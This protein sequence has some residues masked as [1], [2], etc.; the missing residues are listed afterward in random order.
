MRYY[1]LLLCLALS[2]CDLNQHP[3]DSMFDDYVGR[4]ANV[5]AEQALPLP[6]TQTTQLPDKSELTLAIEPIT[7]GLLDSYELRKCG[8]F[9]IIA[10][11]NSVL[12]KVQ[13]Q[14]REFDFQLALFAGLQQCLTNEQISV[15]L[16]QTLSSIYAKK[17]TQLPSYLGNLLFTSDAMRAQLTSSTWLAM[18]NQITNSE[19]LRSF[20]TL[21]LAYQPENSVK[22]LDLASYQEILEK[23]NLMGELWF[24]MR[25]AIDKLSVITQ[26]LHQ[27][28][29][30]IIC[31]SG[32]DTTRFRYLNNVFNHVYVE[33]IQPYLAR[34][35]AHYFK[36]EPYVTL[37]EN[38]HPTYTYPIRKTHADFRQAT[39][40]HVKYWQGLFERCGVKV[41]R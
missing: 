13:D 24:S 9:N 35:D 28:D 6:T 3:V 2:G 7:I 40:S 17:Q 36:L 29:H 23:N 18:D 41:S 31:Q 30:K 10:E 15:E 33:Q 11:R 38:S 32:R 1:F 5:Q 37:L 4:I 16:K 25:N 22:E 26:Q 8:L 34:I 14:F 19:L 20:H 12:G 21:Y 39:L 27:H